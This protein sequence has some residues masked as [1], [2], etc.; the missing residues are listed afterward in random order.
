MKNKRKKL[1]A[2]V[3]A[4]VLGL[5]FPVYPVHA[6]NNAGNFN[7]TGGTALK[8]WY[9]YESSGQL[10]FINSGTYT[11]EGDGQETMDE[12]Q[13]GNNFVGTITIKNVN[14]KQM[15]V[16]NTANLTLMLEGTNTLREGLIFETGTLTINS[17]TNGSLTATGSGSAGIGGGNNGAGR[18][19]IINGGTVIATSDYGV[20]I[21]GSREGS[22]ITI[23]GGTVTAI[24]YF[25]A[26]AIGGGKAGGNSI[27]INGGTVTAKT[28][29]LYGEGIGGGA[30]NDTIK[31]SGGSVSASSIGGTPTDGNGQ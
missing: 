23:N 1:I 2:C 6:E 28:N 4:A 11:V 31:I 24:S 17:E 27:I 7:V 29:V 20:G 15:S 10:T 3:L 21:G 12:I 13:V 26:A 8:D 25:G 14:V 5:F 16:K 19:I 30:G 9:Y 18:N 22:S